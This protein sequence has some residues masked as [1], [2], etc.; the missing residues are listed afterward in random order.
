[1]P[2]RSPLVAD[3]EKLNAELGRITHRIFTL[4]LAVSAA[5]RED[6]LC[7]SGVGAGNPMRR[8]GKHIALNLILASAM[9]LAACGGGS[10]NELPFPT[11]PTVNIVPPSTPSPTPPVV[12][13]PPVDPRIVTVA[14]RVLY[15]RRFGANDLDVTF[16]AAIYRN[17]IE[18]H[19]S[20]GGPVR[21]NSGA[22]V[23]GR[24]RTNA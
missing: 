17:S 16:R 23:P 12:T 13:T 21:G 10:V 6:L 1:M 18:T 4:Q 24:T 15:L 5:L 20:R 2:A 11:A 14:G 19:C 9:P 3:I 22:V 7:P 8:S